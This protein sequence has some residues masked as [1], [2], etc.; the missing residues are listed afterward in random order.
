MSFLLHRDT[1][2]A[3]VRRRGPVGNRV[4]QHRADLRMSAL[5]VLGLEL[6]LLDKRTPSR[7]LQGYA[8]LMQQVALVNVDE[9]LAHRAAVLGSGLRAQQ[10]RMGSVD[11]VIA[12]TALVH[13]LT[14]VTHATHLFA[15]IP[16]LAVVDWSVP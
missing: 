12:A 16:G 13:G 10:R 9:A 2:M 7:H 14:L 15:A 8:A 3:W 11:L 5:T 1:C 4:V 6:W